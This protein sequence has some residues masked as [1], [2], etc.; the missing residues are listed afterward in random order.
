M[1]RLADIWNRRNLLTA[2]LTVWSAMTLF[3]GLARSYV[4]IVIARLGVGAGTVGS[5]PPTLSMIADLFPLQKRGFAMGVFH[6]GGGVGFALGIGIGG[7]VTN[8]FGWRAAMIYFGALGLAVA[9]LLLLAVRAP[10]RR[11]SH[12]NALTAHSAPKVVDVMRFVRRQRSL[13]HVGIALILITLVDTAILSWTVMYFVR[14][15]GLDVFEA[16]GL[17]ATAWLVTGLSGTLLGGYLMDRLARRDPRWHTRMIVCVCLVSVVLVPFVY[18]GPTVPFALGTMFV[19]TLVWNMWIA[20]QATILTGLDGSRA[21]GITWAAL[22]ATALL[23]AKGLGPLLVGMIT[24]L[25]EPFVGVHAL[26]YAMLV[27]IVFMIWGAPHFHLAGR[28]IVEDY[29]GASNQ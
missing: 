18:L 21:R 9:M 26:R 27:G 24:D 8:E 15:H 14:S 25:L 23:F 2:A 12:G 1:G 22:S 28:T 29:E 4:E 20:P 11:D 16:G 3:M 5:Y 17:L 13:I 10:T 19:T 7:F 6:I